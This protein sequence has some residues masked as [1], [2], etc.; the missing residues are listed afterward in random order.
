MTTLYERTL[1][2]NSVDGP[3][4]IAAIVSRRRDIDELERIAAV[5]SGR[6]I[7]ADSRVT[8]HGLGVGRYCRMR[9]YVTCTQSQLAD[10]LEWLAIEGVSV[11]RLH[12]YLGKRRYRLALRTLD[13]DL[14]CRLALAATRR[15]LSE[16]A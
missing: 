5:F 8:V 11:E 10:A 12:E 1:D 9:L 14:V 16:A 13:I 7:K 3:N 2:A 4:T 6:G 15:P